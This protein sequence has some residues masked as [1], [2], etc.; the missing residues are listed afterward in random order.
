MLGSGAVSQTGT[1]NR[2]GTARDDPRTPQ[3]VDEAVATPSNLFDR[4]DE[5]T[6]ADP[7]Q[8]HDEIELAALEPVGKCERFCIRF[9]RH[10]AHGGSRNRLPPIGCDECGQFPSA[11]AL[12]N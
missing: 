2:L 6:C 12:E 11:A 8:Q 7:C 9:E 1:C 4:G 10:F 5:R 3:C